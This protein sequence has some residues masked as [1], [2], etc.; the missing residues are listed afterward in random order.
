M[1]PSSSPQ[2]SAVSSA[3]SPP[4]T[5]A[6]ANRTWSRGRLRP[7]HSCIISRSSTHKSAPTVCYLFMLVS[8]VAV[9]ACLLYVASNGSMRISAILSMSVSSCCI[10]GKWHFHGLSLPL[11]EQLAWAIGQSWIPIVSVGL[12][13]AQ[14]K[15]TPLISHNHADYSSGIKCQP[16]GSCGTTGITTYCRWRGICPGY[17][18]WNLTSSPH[19]PVLQSMNFFTV[20]FRD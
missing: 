2:L 9:S 4:Q 5:Q 17:L 14:T 7:G 1:H 12:Q 10:S 8:A 15:M 16:T 18:E 20:T 6:T 3:K 19:L 11:D 13:T